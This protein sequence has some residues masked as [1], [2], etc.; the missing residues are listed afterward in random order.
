[1][2]ARTVSRPGPAP[3]E[4]SAF[5]GRQP[6][7]DRSLEVYGYE[8]LYRRGDEETAAVTDG[9]SA[10][11]EVA[12]DAFLEFG[13]DTLVADRYAFINLT[14]NVLLSGVCRTLPPHRVVL[15]LLEDLP[16]DHRVAAEVETLA[17]AGYR[18]ALD[19]FAPDDPRTPLLPFTSV[20]KLDLDAFDERTLRAVVGKIRTCP[21]ALI[22]ERVETHEQL[23]MC[24]SLGIGYY[25]GFFFARPT[26]VHGRRVPVER[27]TALRVLTLLAD[28]DTPL[29]VLAQAVAADV[30][31]SYQ[32]LR[33]ANSAL[34][35]PAG[36]IESIPAAILRIGRDRLR[37]WLSVMAL[38][39]LDGTPSAAL[40]LALTRAR[41]CE[42]LAQIAGARSPATW[43]MAG[44][45]SALDLLFNV[46]VDELLRDL[47]LTPGVVNAIVHRSGELG[48]SIDAIV[49]FERGAWPSA[50]SLG[51]T[52]GDFTDAFRSA[53]EWT[54]ECESIFRVTKAG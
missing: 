47:P 20:V 45:F 41:M 48:A 7:F 18:I 29:H 40:D 16:C 19:D 1:M 32:V 35:A 43:F 24:R 31:L 14:R 50:R 17:G 5:I 27:L 12:L 46:P 2:P 11:A 44:L 34:S 36:A 25:Q 4:R 28:P 9:D 52:P 13:L 3:V 10:S 15:E 49:A 23:E 8:L 38:S 54:R 37:A 30:K 21:V 53:L 51:L 33:F 22:A 39:G 26:V 6:I 42:A